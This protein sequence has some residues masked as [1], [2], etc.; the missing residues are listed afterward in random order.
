MASENVETVREMA[1]VWGERGVDAYADHL[2]TVAVADIVWREDPGWPDH[3]E[4]T[5]VDA[6]RE[7]LKDRVESSDFGITIDELIDGGD[8]V[9]ALLR[10]T[11]HGRAS[12]AQA[13]L[14]VAI[15]TGFMDGKVAEVDFYLDRD[16]ALRAFER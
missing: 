2:A 3:A 15:I 11:V 12:G 7:L 8:R 1:E 6:I 5:G 16:A 4:V 14:K 13:D 10:W 9:L